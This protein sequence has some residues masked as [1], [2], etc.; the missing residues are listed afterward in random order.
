MAYWI[1]WTIFSILAFS[2]AGLLLS[3]CGMLEMSLEINNQMKDCFHA[4]D[5]G[6]TCKLGVI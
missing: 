2:V 6:Q 5:K 3:Y 1:Y 4:V